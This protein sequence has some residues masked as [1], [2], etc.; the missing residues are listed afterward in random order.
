MYY[1]HN[2]KYD[3]ARVYFDSV[4][5]EYPETQWAAKASDTLS[6]MP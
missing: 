5:Q 4:V 6:Q 2:M 1:H 3:S